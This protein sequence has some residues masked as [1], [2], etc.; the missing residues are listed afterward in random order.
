MQI[1]GAADWTDWKFE[2]NKGK[3]GLFYLIKVYNCCIC[4]A[5]IGKHCMNVMDTDRCMAAIEKGYSVII[6]TMLPLQCSPKNNIIIG[7]H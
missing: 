5:I 7:R 3:L 1:S 4:N 6:N 2:S